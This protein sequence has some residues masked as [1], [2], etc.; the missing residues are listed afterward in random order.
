[1][2]TDEFEQAFSYFPESP[3]YDDAEDSLFSIV[4]TAFLAGWNAA[5]GKP[6]EPQ[7]KVIRLL[8]KQPD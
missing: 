5:Q 7:D 1:M 6:P 3:V 8:Y 2:K 4:R